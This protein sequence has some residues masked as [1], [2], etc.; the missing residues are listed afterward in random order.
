[1]SANDTSDFA[2][3]WVRLII[4]LV[5]LGF[6]GYYVYIGYLPQFGGRWGTIIGYLV[7]GIAIAQL[8]DLLWRSVR[9][10]P[11]SN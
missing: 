1:M 5:A 7:I 3:W 6:A 2:P 10:P 8:F 9:K 4:G 11:N